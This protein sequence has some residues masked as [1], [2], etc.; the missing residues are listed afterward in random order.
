MCVALVK[1]KVIVCKRSE[2]KAEQIII[3]NDTAIAR[4]TASLLRRLLQHTPILPFSRGC[5]PGFKL[6]PR[7]RQRIR[8]NSYNQHSQHVRT[9]TARTTHFMLISVVISNTCDTTELDYRAL[10]VCNGEP[11]L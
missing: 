5:R 2:V 9:M 4:R 3:G 10:R 1:G 6:T 7:T 8:Y 11:V